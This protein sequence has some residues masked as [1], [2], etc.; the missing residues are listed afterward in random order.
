NEFVRHRA[1]EATVCELDDVVVRAGGVAATLEDLAVDADV[2]EFV[3]DDGEAAA[4]RIRQHVADQCGLAGAEE[5]GDD[6]A[7]HARERSVR[8]CSSSK[9][10]GG[11][12]ATSPRL[13]ISGRPRHG[14]MPSAAPARRRAPSISAAAFSTSSPPKM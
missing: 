6:R 7:G 13:R 1:A 14:R 4:L 8:H 5:A 3:D 11:T 10:T 2:A 9:P 12:R